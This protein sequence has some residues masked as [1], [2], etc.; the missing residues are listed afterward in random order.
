MTSHRKLTFSYLGIIQMLIRG[1]SKVIPV[2]MSWYFIRFD[3][4][5]SDS[6]FQL[7]SW[8]GFIFYFQSKSKPQKNEL[9]KCLLQIGV[10]YNNWLISEIV[11]LTTVYL[12]GG[13]PGMR[14]LLMWFGEGSLYMTLP[15]GIKSLFS[16]LNSN[17]LTSV[18]E[19]QSYYYKRL[20][21]I[22]HYLS[23]DLK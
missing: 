19:E 22:N 13:T 17:R 18:A 3:S 20:V 14:L 15:L 7:Q 2:M 10:C 21:L 8:A 16:W 12:K 23:N 5:I 9:W 11:F 6:N 4:H 1:Q